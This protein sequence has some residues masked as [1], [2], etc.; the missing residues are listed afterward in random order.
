MNDGRD[1]IIRCILSMKYDIYKPRLFYDNKQIH[2]LV[3]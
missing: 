1:V 2:S 3:Q